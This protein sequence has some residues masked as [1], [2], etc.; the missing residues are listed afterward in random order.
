MIFRV[1]A[2]QMYVGILFADT[3]TFQR[4]NGECVFSGAIMSYKKL[5]LLRVV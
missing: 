5:N 4:L 2:G 1:Y 3:H